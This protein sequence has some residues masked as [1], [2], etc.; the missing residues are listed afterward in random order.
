MPGDRL[1]DVLLRVGLSAHLLAAVAE[2]IRQSGQRLDQPLFA[3]FFVPSA[4]RFGKPDGKQYH[5]VPRFMRKH[6]TLI[7][8]GKKPG[9]R[10]AG[11]EPRHLATRLR[12]PDTTA[13]DSDLIVLGGS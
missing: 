10:P 1:V 11:F 13:P 12:K 9:H 3:P 4:H 5:Q 2:D 6:T 7:P 8:M